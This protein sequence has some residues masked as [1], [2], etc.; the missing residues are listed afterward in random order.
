MTLIRASLNDQPKRRLPA[1]AMIVRYWKRICFTAAVGVVAGFTAGAASRTAVAHLPAQETTVLQANSARQSAVP[2]ENAADL[3][4]LRARNRRLE[5][6]VTV[7]R[8]KVEHRGAS[9]VP[10]P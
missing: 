4:R 8:S 5:A 2:R 6:L 9:A 1:A 10:N 3:D 7:L